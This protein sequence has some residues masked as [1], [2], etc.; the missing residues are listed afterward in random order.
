MRGLHCGGT[1][2]RGF[3]TSNNQ[4]KNDI[5]VKV[6]GADTKTNFLN[7]KISVGTNI[8]KSIENPGGDEK[9]KI[10]CTAQ[11][12]KVKVSETDSQADYLQPKLVAGN[13][14]TI[15]KQTAGSVESL[16]IEATSTAEKKIWVYDFCKT[17]QIAVGDLDPK[18]AAGSWLTNTQ[19]FFAHVN[20]KV[21]GFIGET[22]KYYT[23]AANQHLRFQIKRCT[24]N[25]LRTAD[26]DMSTGINIINLDLIPPVSQPNYG[27]YFGHYWNKSA[28]DSNVID[29]VT[30]MYLDGIVNAGEMLFIAHC[31][32]S[33]GAAFYGASSRVF[34][35]EV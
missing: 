22:P 34:L 3:S 33:A 18:G 12:I 16:K 13:N 9:L 21:I 20:M 27:F 15:T 29:G 10:E 31:N 5:Y 14:I 35:Q 32:I 23:N 4:D 26:I 1:G 2:R 6:S 25:S 19:G 11:D 17:A 24:M 7:E 30:G 28:L 8:S